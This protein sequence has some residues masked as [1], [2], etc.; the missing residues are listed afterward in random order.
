M[1]KQVDKNTIKDISLKHNARPPFVEKDFY[2][3]KILKELANINYSGADLVFTGGTCLSKGYKLIKRFSEDLDFR[4]VANSEFTRGQRKKFRE[5]IIDKIKEIPDVE[6]LPDSLEKRN[7]SKFFSFYVDYPREFSIHNSLRK[8]LKLEFAFE[9]VLIP[10]NKC[11]IISIL[12]EYIE[13]LESTEIEC[14]SPI[15]VAADKFSALM[16]RIDIKDRTKKTGSTANDATIIR[17]L[18]DLAALEK[19][20]SKDEFKKCL[21][22][23]LKT[24]QGRGGSN[25]DLNL[26]DFAQQTLDKL[27]LD[28]LY[29]EEYREFVEALSYAQKDEITT[30]KAALASFERIINFIR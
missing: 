8:G 18:H 1:K 12:G 29:E 25:S 17:H 22:A 7:E 5:F 2:S 11:S 24:D 20:I 28:N 4:I 6:Y 16:W 27:K 3:V 23:S 15:E 10:T 21:N 19:L 26:I 30:F 14:I 9:N 13:G